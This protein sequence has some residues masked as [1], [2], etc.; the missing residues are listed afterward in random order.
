MANLLGVLPDA[1]SLP[2]SAAGCSIVQ[3]SLQQPAPV[4]GTTLLW[5]RRALCRLIY[6]VPQNSKLPWLTSSEP[7]HL[8]Q[9]C[10]AC[11]FAAWTYQL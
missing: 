7:M 4:L 3:R 1:S 11:K 10:N 8:K 5:H 9:A 2:S 6:P